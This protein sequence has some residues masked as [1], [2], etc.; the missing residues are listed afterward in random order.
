VVSRHTAATLRAPLA[1]E[2]TTSRSVTTAQW[3][4]NMQERLT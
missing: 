4:T 1:M 2:A 3:H